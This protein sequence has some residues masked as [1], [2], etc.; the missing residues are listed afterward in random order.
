MGST[1]CGQTVFVVRL[2]AVIEDGI[3]VQFLA[4]RC[5]SSF[6]HVPM[7]NE[8]VGCACAEQYGETVVVRSI[9]ALQSCVDIY[10]LES[11][12]P[13][14]NVGARDVARPFS[15][16]PAI[17]YAC[18][19]DAPCWSQPRIPESL[20]AVRYPATKVSVKMKLQA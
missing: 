1:L 3:V 7:V 18:H 5:S 4:P 11:D 17:Q 2:L 12:W 10:R 15:H 9:G 16:R 6:F 8:R 20:G 13:H 19:Y 14:S